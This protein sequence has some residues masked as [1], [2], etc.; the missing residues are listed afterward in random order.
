M[1]RL[2]RR[3]VR[4]LLLATASLLA[5]SCADS[6]CHGRPVPA[7]TDATAN[8]GGATFVYAGPELGSLDPSAATGIPEYQVVLDLFEGPLVLAPDDGPPRPGLAERHEVSPDGRVWTFHLRREARWSDG[9]PVTADDVV[10]AVR[11][12][13]DPATQSP[14][15][16]QLWGIEGARAWSTG[17][18]DAPPGPEGVGVAAPDPHTLVVRLA[19]PAAAFPW[20]VAGPAFLPLPRHVV[21]RHGADWWRPE[22][23]VT[24]GP[25]AVAEWRPRERL[26][27]T[28]NPQFHGA[29]EVALARVERRTI[30]DDAAALRWFDTGVVHWLNTNVPRERV[31]E[32]RRA[33]APELHLMPSLCLNQLVLRV[34]RP[35]LDDVRL[36]RA[37]T[38]L[39]DR[40]ALVEDVLQVG[41]APLATVVPDVFAG[42]GLSLPAGPGFDPEAARA[43]LAAAGHPGGAALPPL[44][45]GYLG[46]GAH[47][48]VATALTDGWRRQGV[49]SVEPQAREWRTLVAEAESGDFELAALPWCAESPDPARFLAPYVSDSPDNRGG[50]RDA[51]FDELYTRIIASPA[52]PQRNELV[53]QALRRLNELVPAIPMFHVRRAYLVDESVQGIGP[54]PLG[55]H[56]LRWVRR[57]PA[58]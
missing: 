39:V 49:T 30:G 53:A 16:G 34:D 48:L 20:V 6:G 21:A 55:V 51:A 11:R 57:D 31:I 37:L 56:L 43:E 8:A 46:V 36:R 47:A 41:M 26:V 17:A 18:L 12:H 58:S 14:L 19:E 40:R 50:F 1:D 25:F 4:L 13:L 28:R 15:A 5:A 2:R 32:A 3:T 29:A 23:L 45:Y 42:Q 44:R 54:N 10:A 38:Q 22:H 52:G 27:L 24:N 9:A 7:A 35:P 33:Q